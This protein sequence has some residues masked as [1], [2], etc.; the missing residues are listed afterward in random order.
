[1][2]GAPGVDSKSV[3]AETLAA[4]GVKV[5]ADDV[6]AVAQSLDRIQAAA[7]VLLPPTSFD[8]TIEAFYRL[9]DPD[10]AGGVGR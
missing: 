1:M 5:S 4:S 8:E 7:A 6:A 9:L 3:L 10:D 2:S